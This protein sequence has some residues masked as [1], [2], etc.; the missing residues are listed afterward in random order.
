MLLYRDGLHTTKGIMRDVR[1]I[2]F[3]GKR[4]DLV[5]IGE[6]EFYRVTGE[7][8]VEKFIYWLD[9]QLY[10]MADK[11]AKILVLMK[12]GDIVPIEDLMK[13]RGVKR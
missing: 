7:E 4:P 11:H 3:N 8:N 12:A 1:G 10:P 5:V 13:M 9:T 6:F 2:I